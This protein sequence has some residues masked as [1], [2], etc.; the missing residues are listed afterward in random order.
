[1]CLHGITGWG[2]HFGRLADQHLADLYR[3]L[4]PDLIGHGESSWEPPW[5]VEAQLDALELA[6]GD[7]PAT[8]V[9]HSYGGR[10]AFEMAA[11]RP[12]LVERLVL[13]DPAIFLPP[14]VALQSAESSLGDRSYASPAE[15][16]ERR[17]DESML[18][19]APRDLVAAELV[20]HLT[21]HPG[22]RWRYRYSQASVI[23]AY[24]EMATVPSSFARVRVPTLLVLGRDSYLPYLLIEDH[25]AALGALLT[26]VSVSGG[27]TVLWDA[28]DETGRTI[29]TY[30]DG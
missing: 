3:V 14:H 7:A 21:E 29:R 8:W 5:S 20:E 13:L 28:L 10:I 18:H 19:G 15:A 1:M 6:V 22:G 23:A 17:Y 26:E 9:G 16:L 27:H 25:R 4:A 24:G 2:G 30:L 11:R 12:E